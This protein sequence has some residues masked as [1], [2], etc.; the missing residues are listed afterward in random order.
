MPKPLLV[1]E[2]NPY[3]RDPDDALLPWPFGC[4][5]YR[6]CHK[7]LGLREETYLQ[8]FD[9][10]NLLDEVRW[11]AP[12]ARASAATLIKEHHVLILLGRPYCAGSELPDQDY[13][14]LH[15]LCDGTHV[16]L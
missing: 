4:A 12:R 9:R 5:G 6:L 11:S 10:A 2:S 7:V 13:Y 14:F 1:G 16:K 15:V 3:S 8:V